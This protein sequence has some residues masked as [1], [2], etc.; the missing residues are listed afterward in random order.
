M[1]QDGLVFLVDRQILALDFQRCGHV[2]AREGIQRL[3]QQPAR[4]I[5]H[6][7][8]GRPR[9]AGLD[10]GQFQ[11]RARH[12]L[13]LIADALQVGDGLDD[14]EDQPQIAGCRL[15]AR[16]DAAA[17]LVQ[18][19]FERVYLQV[20]A[21]H[22]G[23]QL[24]VAVFQRADRVGDL[25]LHHTAHVQHVAAQILELLVVLLR[26]VVADVVLA[27]CHGCAPALSRNGR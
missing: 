9:A 25:P 10:I 16:Q 26:D 8:H 17:F 20:A 15:A 21:D 6:V 7:T 23:G 4:Q 11:H 24:R 14:G 27:Q 13:G 18:V 2:H 22:R 5:A 1:A 3:V 19:Q 12:P